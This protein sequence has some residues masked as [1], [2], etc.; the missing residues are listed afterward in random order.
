[1]SFSAWTSVQK[2][3]CQ[4]VANNRRGAHLP[5]RHMR[6]S[7]WCQTH[8]HATVLQRCKCLTHREGN[9]CCAWKRERCIHFEHQEGFVFVC[10][11]ITASANQ[12][13]S[14]INGC[15][16]VQTIDNAAGVC[17]CSVALWYGCV[18]NILLT[19]CNFVV[20]KTNIFPFILR[21][22]VSEAQS[23][24]AT[25]C[26]KSQDEALTQIK[27]YFPTLYSH[28][29]TLKSLHSNRGMT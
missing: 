5:C 7:Q 3:G 22:S 23:V 24:M 4:E 15:K 2:Q 6:G 19:A 14:W 9:K 28:H 10:V 12:I 11:K 18:K 29:V 25:N 26:N 13:H 1:M 27:R 20:L 21:M 16:P 17:V 8:P